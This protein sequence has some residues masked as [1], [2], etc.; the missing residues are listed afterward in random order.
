MFCWYQ[1]FNFEQSV[2]INIVFV[3]YFIINDYDFLILI[4]YV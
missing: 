1:G 4:I 3:D 2:M